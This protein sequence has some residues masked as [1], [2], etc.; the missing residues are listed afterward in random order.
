MPQAWFGRKINSLKR[1]FS[2][3]PR[4]VKN[5]YYNA[6]IYN[7]RKQSILKLLDILGL[8]QD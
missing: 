3:F 6:L 1:G 4:P 8:Y 2:V 7:I 5:L